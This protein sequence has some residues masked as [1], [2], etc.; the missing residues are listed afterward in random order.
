MI[1]VFN[2]GLGLPIFRTIQQ[3]PLIRVLVSEGSI[4]Q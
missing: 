1:R 4:R 3:K 2:V